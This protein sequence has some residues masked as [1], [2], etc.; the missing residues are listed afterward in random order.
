MSEQARKGFRAISA[1]QN[2][3]GIFGEFFMNFL[4]I[5]WE[6]FEDVWLGG[7]DLGIFGEFFRNFK[8]HTDTKL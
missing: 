5:L 8:L 2:F 4:G 7:L 6:L 1:S 3:W